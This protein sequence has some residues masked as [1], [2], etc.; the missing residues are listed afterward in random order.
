MKT[1]D[2]STAEELAEHIRKLHFTAEGV[3]SDTIDGI[4]RLIEARVAVAT[5]AETARAN[6]G[7]A[8]HQWWRDSGLPAEW[9]RKYITIAKTS[10][11]LN[12]SDKNQLRLIGIVSDEPESGADADG[13]RGTARQ[14]NPFAWVKFAGKVRANLSMDD[15][16]T[17]DDHERETARLHLK[18]LV[19]LYNALEK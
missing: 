10:K 6:L 3:Q 14:S 18:P 15:I 5:L 7:N 19:E 8:Y 17:M 16:S 12:L 1:I 13:T 9:D 11:R 2:I 4:N